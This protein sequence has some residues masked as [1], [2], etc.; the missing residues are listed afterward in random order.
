[1]WA[2][3]FSPV[4]WD[5]MGWDGVGWSP[6]AGFGDLLVGAQQWH[7]HPKGNKAPCPEETPPVTETV[8]QFR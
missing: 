1:M 2:V 8:E 7:V 3:T 5:E 4:G 6:H